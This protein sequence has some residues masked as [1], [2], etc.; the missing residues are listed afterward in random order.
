[1]HIKIINPKSDGRKVYDNTGSVDQ[2]VSYLQ[3]EA[4]ES[5]EEREDIFFDQSRNHVSAEEVKARING[6]CKGVR[7]D[8]EKFFSI[9]VSPSEEELR[10]IENDDEQLRRYVRQVME[11]YAQSFRIKDKVLSSEDLVWFATVHQDREVKNLDLNNLS[12]LSAK[13]QVRVGVLHDSDTEKDQKEI[14]RIFQRAIRREQHKLDGE[15]FGVGDKKPGLNKHVHIVVSRRDQEQKIMLN[16]RTQ[17]KRFHIRKFQEKGARDFQ[18]MFGYTK[19]TI[20]P[21]FYQKY[22]QK[23]RQY[24]SEKIDKATEGINRHLGEEKIDAQ[25]LQDIGEKYQYS[26]AFFVNL[27]KLKYRTQQGNIPHDP[28]FFVERGR[29]QK[30][31][32][33]FHTLDYKKG[34]EFTAQ[35]DT[36]STSAAK[37]LLQRLGGLSTGPAMMKETL[38]LD[39]ERK[40]LRKYRERGVDGGRHPGDH[41]EM[42]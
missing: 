29:D 33:Y 20:Q 12:F 21:G 39:E 9:V 16:P 24:Y 15:V 3:H 8:Q 11:N 26:R 17:M 7:A 6:N 32:E 30:T 36:G 5:E 37:R 27:H 18:R 25:R 19:E 38:L 1:M 14:E 40:R 28:Y 42:S 34:Q 41:N 13:E 22:S 23:D 4:K 35:A 2:L 10:H 31:S